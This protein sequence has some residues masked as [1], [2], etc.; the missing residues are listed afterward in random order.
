MLLGDRA[1]AGD[2]RVGTMQQRPQLVEVVVRRTAEDAVSRLSGAFHQIQ[3]A[4][5][6]R[7]AGDEDDA[8]QRGRPANHG[9]RAV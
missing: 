4:V 3:V 7:A 8:H 9:A 2:P 6:E 5:R 1:G